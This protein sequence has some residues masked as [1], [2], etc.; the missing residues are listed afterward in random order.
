MGCA[1]LEGI[2]GFAT[3]AAVMAWLVWYRERE[4]AWLRTALLLAGIG[5]SFKITAGLVPN[6]LFALTAAVLGVE[7]RAGA[8][9]GGPAGGGGAQLP[10]REW[11]LLAALCVVPVCPWLVHATLTTGNP[12]F[13]MFAS[14]IP[15]HDFSPELARQWEY[16]NRYINWAI[17]IGKRWTVLQRREILLGVA[18][19]TTLTGAVVVR[20]LRS[21]VARA[22]GVV[23]TG[24]AIAQLAAVGLYLRYW[25]PLAS[26]LQL[27]LLALAGPALSGRT[28]RRL[29]VAAA[30]LLSL[31][32]GRQCLRSVD[33]DAA[34]LVRTALGVEAPGEFLARHYPIVPLDEQINRELP[35]DA[36]VLMACNCA[37]FY[38]DRPTYCVDTVQGSIRLSPQGA[39]ES[40]VSRLHITHVLSPR[41]LA[42]GG[43]SPS[44]EPA[45][46]QYMIRD[47][48]VAAL[49]P[50][51]E[52]RGHLIGQALD[53][54]LYAL[55]VPA[56]APGGVSPRE[57][58]GR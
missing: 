20:L 7:A 57:L 47:D 31:R 22:A 14:V 35:A 3:I 40:D 46:V 1:Y 48:E 5:T 16:F 18:M 23:S 50:L 13:P 55:D 2:T 54:G 30:L 42:E 56:R 11:A 41:V 6:S 8:T 28:G 9:S 49:R 37:G 4:I 44:N 33:G 53:L 17:V 32:E 58:P 24:T 12:V 10:W 52:R 21:P 29:L 15:S 38:V 26:V 34:G 39:F 27:P 19:A 45:G 25:V 43:P 36:R 51:L